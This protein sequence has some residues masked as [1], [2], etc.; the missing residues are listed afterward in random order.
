MPDKK[1][2]QGKHQKIWAIFSLLI[3]ASLLLSGCGSPQDA[4]VYRIGILSGLDA[5]QPITDGFK[6]QMTELGYVEGENVIYDVQLVSNVANEEG[7]A[8]E[9]LEKFVADEVDLIFTFPTGAASIAKEATA[10]T[11]IPVVFANTNVEGSD[12]IK[13]V[14]EPGGNLTG[15]QSRGP[16]LAP[17]RL[18]FLQQIAP[19]VKKVLILHNPDYASSLGSLKLLE[20]A[21]LGLGIELVVV[22]IQ[23]VADI[24]TGLQQQIQDGQ[25]MI[26]AIL[27]IPEPVNQSPE[28]WKAISTFATEHNLPVAGSTAGQIGQGAIFTYAPDNIEIGKLVAPLAQ[29]IL[30]GAPAG[31]LPI[32]TPEGWL[33]INYK[34]ILDLQLAAP[35]GLLKQANEIIR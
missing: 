33:R 12:L 6:A 10:G 23:N 20:P 17:K 18:E 35:E 3:I 1:N 4:K 7:K 27:V 14:R 21:A 31:T 11:N 29:K 13:N 28:G 15:V 34:R 2:S 25:V 30:Q 9:I 5:F 32:V 24:E 22:N 16:D 26:D 8:R 19:E